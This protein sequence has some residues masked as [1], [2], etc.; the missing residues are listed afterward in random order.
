MI[1]S[2]SK[3]MKETLD[4]IE[5]AGSELL[6][7]ADACKT[8]CKCYSDKIISNI[9]TGLK[10]HEDVCFS[11]VLTVFNFLF[12]AYARSSGQVWIRSGAD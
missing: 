8:A 3:N 2:Q 5:N 11:F 9:N 12:L 10:E 4:T 1:E 6:V 7:E